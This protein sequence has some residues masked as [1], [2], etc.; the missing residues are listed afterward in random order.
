MA[1]KHQ[2][3][4]NKNINIIHIKIGDKKKKKKRK[5][6]KRIRDNPYTSITSSSGDP[7]PSLAVSN[8]E[9]PTMPYYPRVQGYDMTS[10]TQRANQF[11]KTNTSNMGRENE[12]KNNGII[13]ETPVEIK[14]EKKSAI[15]ST[16]TDQ[17]KE[18]AKKENL[19]NLHKNVEEKSNNELLKSM[20][21]K[22]K[23]NKESKSDTS[24]NPAMSRL[25]KSNPEGKHSKVDT[26]IE[27]QIDAKQ[28][29]LLRGNPDIDLEPPVI[30]KPDNA[31]AM[32]P[33]QIPDN[34]SIII[35]PKKDK[36]NVQKSERVMSIEP[37]DDEPLKKSVFK[38]IFG[39]F[40]SNK[41]E[42]EPVDLATSNQLVPIPNN[43]PVVIKSKDDNSDLPT[44]RNL[45]A[46]QSLTLNQLQRMLTK[47]TGQQYPKIYKDTKSIAVKELCDFLNI[48]VTVAQQIKVIEPK[49]NQKK[50]DK[51]MNELAKVSKSKLTKNKN[52]IIIKDATQIINE[53]RQLKIPV[54]EIVNGK[55]KPIEIER[56]RHLVAYEKSRLTTL[57]D[58]SVKSQYT[59]EL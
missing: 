42:E 45:K 24:S 36:D 25:F 35:T 30:L 22:W 33:K 52:K 19:L 23:D 29:K 28:K 14:E 37:I 10:S 9:Y 38:S 26:I 39:A 20:F 58:P 7:M 55:T 46:V 48:P 27:H 18:T 16:F 17:S 21:G 56:L 4:S 15:P 59:S 2:H 53:A 44:P 51:E 54:S 13:P 3:N 34:D 40:V 31:P 41:D 6:T 5:T 50:K 47:L 32:I 11:Y 12:I 43:I 1:K 57:I 8:S 49:E